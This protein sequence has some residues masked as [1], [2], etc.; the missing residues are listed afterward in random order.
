MHS[1]RPWLA[2]PLILIT[3]WVRSGY[4]R[5]KSRDHGIFA[6]SCGLL[7]WQTMHTSSQTTEAR[8]NHGTL[9]GRHMHGERF[10]MAKSLTEDLYSHSRG[11]HRPV[12]PTDP[13]AN[14]NS[15]R[16]KGAGLF[17]EVSLPRREAGLSAAPRSRGLHHAHYPYAYF[18]PRQALCALN[19]PLRR[20]QTKKKKPRNTFIHA[21]TGGARPGALARHANE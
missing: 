2:V 16:D 12:A 13:V 5:Q 21:G 6:V 14:R 10:A 9:L 1:S 8:D 15:V 11:L 20:G 17:D 18:P 3:Q 4:A 19:A 7:H